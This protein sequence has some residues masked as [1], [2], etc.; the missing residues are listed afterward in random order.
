MA[1]ISENNK[2]IAKNTIYLYIRQIIVIIVSLY[3][4]RVLL[5]VLGASDYGL[6]GVVAGVLTMFGMFRGALQIGTQRF[7]NVAMAE[8]DERKLKKT[9]SVAFGVHVFISV[10]LLLLLQTVGLWFLLNYLNIPDGRM[11]AAIWVYE[12]SCIG[13]IANLL[14]LPFQSCIIAREHMNIYAYMSIYDVIMKLAMIFLIQYLTYDKLILYSVLLFVISISSILIYNYYCRKNFYECNFKIVKDKKMTREIATYCGWN[15][16]GGSIGPLTNQGVNIL[17]NIFFGT[18]V[19]AARGLSIVVNSYIMQFVSNFQLA[20]NPQIV[21]LYASKEYD[22]FNN[23]IVNNC[24]IA[25]YLF[26]L[27]AVPAFLEI[28]YV[29]KLWLGEYP[30]YTDVFLR[31]VLIQ[32]FFQTLNKP[33]NMSVHASGNIKWMNILNTICMLVTLPLCYFALKLGCSPIV[34]YWINLLFFIS[35]GGVCL[36]YSN[37]YTNLP[38]RIILVKVYLNA[39]IGAVLM[40]I[41]PFWISTLFDVSWQRFLIVCFASVFT[42]TIT[43]YFWGLTPGMRKI[44][45]KKININ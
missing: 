35:D 36:Y 14:Q 17:L 13:F 10:V 25:V 44:V 12:L 40:F 45:L 31:I 37:R 33:I 24:R 42:S 30:K 34:V 19:N 39:L 8:G 32:S 6:Y 9:F 26:L 29:L 22:K 3:T 23:L 2:R 27:I 38:I 7:L 28:D 18:V 5:R 1:A 43:I 21:K 41:P 11:N 16:L 4:S 20:A 15:I